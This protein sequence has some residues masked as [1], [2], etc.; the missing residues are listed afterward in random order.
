MIQI[1][2]NQT[3]DA[4]LWDFDGTLANSAA[5]NIAITKQILAKV[6][7]RLTGANL[8]TCLQSESAYHVANHAAEHWRELYRDFFGMNDAE[9][10]EAGPMWDGHQML[11][12]TEVTLFEH[13]AST[14]QALAS[15]PQ[16][17]CSANSTRNIG[18]VLDANGLSG[19]FNSVIGYEGLLEHEQKPAAHGGVQCLQEIFG[20]ANGQSVVYI[21]DHIADVIFSRDLAERLGPAATVTS[22]VVTHS[23][24]RPESWSQQPDLVIQSPAELTAFVR[25]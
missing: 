21:G 5:K 6:A 9:I 17:I 15:V 18:R 11:D 19:Y 24:A 25:D 14:V 16:G 3:I 1:K 23:G 13:V 2:K 4:V 20:Q 7:P 8:P 12:E 10:E 22:I